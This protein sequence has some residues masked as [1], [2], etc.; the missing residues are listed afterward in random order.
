MLPF[1]SSNGHSPESVT[2]VDIPCSQTLSAVASWTGH[3]TDCTV[4]S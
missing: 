3:A 2:T 4:S 1:S